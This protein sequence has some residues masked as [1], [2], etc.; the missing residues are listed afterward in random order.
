MTDLEQRILAFVGARCAM[1][2]RY[3]TR[4][5]ILK[6]VNDVQAQKAIEALCQAAMI[7]P[8]ALRRAKAPVRF[9]VTDRT[10]TS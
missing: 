3:P 1:G 2:H 5:D 7:A 10:S 4:A 6:H 9:Q 8:V